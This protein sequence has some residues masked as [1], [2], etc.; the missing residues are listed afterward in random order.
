MKTL[1]R[2]LVGLVNVSILFAACACAGDPLFYAVTTAND[3][4]TLDPI[5][6][7]FSY[8]GKFTDQ[9]EDPDA[10]CGLGIAADGNLYGM[11]GSLIYKFNTS[12]GTATLQYPGPGGIKYQYG[13]GMTASPDGTLYAYGIYT[14]T[15]TYLYTVDPSNRKATLIGNMGYGLGG[16]LAFD[17]SGDLFITVA[18]GTEQLYGVNPMTGAATFI[19]NTGTPDAFAMAFEGNTLYMVD[20]KGGIWTVDTATGSS[21]QISTLDHSYGYISAMIS[22][23]LLDV[24]EPSIL[25]LAALGGLALLARRCKSATAP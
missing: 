20:L 3:F 8:I 21:T 4:G 23:G 12:T 19:G 11:D 10:I 7:S 14:R 1:S 15:S 24:P 25:G 18:N 22:P 2:K 6:G 17:E 5:T 13:V 16:P 9:F